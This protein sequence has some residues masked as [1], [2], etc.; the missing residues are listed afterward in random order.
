MRRSAVWAEVERSFRRYQKELVGEVANKEQLAVLVD[1]E[2]IDLVEEFLT[3]AENKLDRKF[4][5]SVFYGLCLHIRSVVTRGQEPR[6]IDKNQ[7]TDILSNYKKEYLL[8]AELAEKIG[9][10]YDIEMPLEEIILITLF[11]SMCRRCI[12]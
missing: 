10:I 5:S 6:E 11:M 9:T 1:K 8:S 2:I 4:A 7:I 12:C 3:N